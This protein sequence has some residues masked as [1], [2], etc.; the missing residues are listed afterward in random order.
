MVAAAAQ[1]EPSE[2]DMDDDDDLLMDLSHDDLDAL[3][4]LAEPEPGTGTNTVDG[5]QGIALAEV[6]RQTLLKEEE[7]KRK[8]TAE[9]VD[10][11]G[12]ARGAKQPNK[13]ASESAE[14]EVEL[15]S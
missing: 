15:R 5:P 11:E 10:K 1:L 13:S 6:V 4:P 7:K 12:G 2:I 8:A 9:E 14:M 3:P